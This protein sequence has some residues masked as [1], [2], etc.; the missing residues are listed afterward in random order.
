MKYRVKTGLSWGMG[1]EAKRAEPGEVR[2]DI[3][4]KSLHWLLAQGMIE[5][6]EEEKGGK[7]DG[8]RSR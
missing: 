6:V 5:P 2:D 7:T 3:P 4:A 1:T 8:I